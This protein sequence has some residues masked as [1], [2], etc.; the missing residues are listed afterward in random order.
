MGRILILFV[1][2]FVFLGSL[3]TALQEAPLRLQEAILSIVIVIMFSIYVF[4]ELEGFETRW[5]AHKI[6]FFLPFQAVCSTIVEILIVYFA[7][8]FVIDPPTGAITSL[9]ACEAYFL[10][11]SPIAFIVWL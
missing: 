10:A 1:E 8:E 11:Y 3:F 5:L 7:I 2:I 9:Q 4:S 6:L